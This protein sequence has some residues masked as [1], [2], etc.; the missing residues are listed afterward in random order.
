MPV[1]KNECANGPIHIEIGSYKFETVCSFT[2]LGSEVN[3][4]NDIS[5]EIKNHVPEANKCLHGLRKHLKSWL[6]S[7]KTRI[8]MYKV[9]VRLVLSHA[10]E[11]WPLSRLD[12]KLLSI[13]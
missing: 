13:F 12:E 4:K 1:T 11:T 6:I 2:Y 7:R 8:M 10:S 5:N 3:C 9:L